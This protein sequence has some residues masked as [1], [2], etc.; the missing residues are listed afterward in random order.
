MN[1]K[2]KSKRSKGHSIRDDD[3]FSQGS[4]TKRSIMS[5]E[6]LEL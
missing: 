4:L 1:L 2:S 6:Y 5:D 3:N